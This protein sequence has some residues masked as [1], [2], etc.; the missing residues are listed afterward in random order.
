MIFSTAT[1]KNCYRSLKQK[2]GFRNVSLSKQILKSTDFDNSSIKMRCYKWNQSNNRCA[3]SINENIFKI[4]EHGIYKCC[5]SSEICLWIII[6]RWQYIKIDNHMRRA[7]PKKIFFFITFSANYWTN[8][9]FLWL[10]FRYSLLNICLCILNSNNYYNP[11]P[12]MCAMRMT[13]NGLSAFI[14]FRTTILLAQTKLAKSKFHFQTIADHFFSL[15]NPFIIV[16][17]WLGN[18]KQVWCCKRLV[19]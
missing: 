9:V 11:N 3:F 16:D 1:F 12:C 2:N 18:I 13:L 6:F 17:T 7:Y 10:F 19:L 15:Q 5:S 4:Y 14:I 8:I